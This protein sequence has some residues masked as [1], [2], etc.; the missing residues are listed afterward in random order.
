[1]EGLGRQSTAPGVMKRDRICFAE[2]PKGRAREAIEAVI[3]SP[4]RH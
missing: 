3:D 4:T 2:I 1:M